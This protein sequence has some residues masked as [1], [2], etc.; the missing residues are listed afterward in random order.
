MLT[1]RAGA[2]P[3]IFAEH[4]HWKEFPSLLP[5]LAIL[6]GAVSG[7]VIN[8][9][10]QIIYNR[11]SGGKVAPELR[12]PPMMFG[13][14][15]FSSGEFC[16]GLTITCDLLTLARYVSYG[17]DGRSKVSIAEHFDRRSSGL[18]LGHQVSLDRSRHR[19]L[20]DRSWILHNLS[21]RT[22]LSRRHLSALR[23][24]RGGRQ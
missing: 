13:S 14:F 7:A 5:F 6:L 15:L 21:G 16:I 24:E 22:Q 2:I 18:T 20:H 4:R 1:F 19:P 11:K 8:V 9:Y 3:I 17:L 10:N 23:G 12:L